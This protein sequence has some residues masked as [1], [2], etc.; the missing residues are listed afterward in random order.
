MLKKYVRL[1]MEPAD[2]A[3]LLGLPLGHVETQI[4]SITHSTKQP[5]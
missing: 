5:I 4:S 3:T 2:I 1:K